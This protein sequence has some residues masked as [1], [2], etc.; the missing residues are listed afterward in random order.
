MCV[1][2]SVRWSLWRGALVLLS[3]LA[4][5]GCGGDDGS[6]DS[7]GDTITDG[8]E[9]AN[10]PNVDGD[11]YPNHLDLDSDGDGIPDAVEAGDAVLETPPV[12]TDGDADADVVDLDSDGDT[13]ADTGELAGD[14]TVADSDGDGTPDFRDLDSDGDGIPDAVEAVDVD[15]ATAAMDTNGDGTPD[16]RDGDSD[17]D[18]IPDAIEAG[19]NPAAPRYTDSDALPDYRDL[20]SDNDGLADSDEDRNCDGIVDAGESSPTSTDTDG[21]GT[22]DL[23]EVVAG[24]DPNNPGSNIPPGDFYFVLPY[25]GPGQSGPLDFSTTIKQADIFF[26][27][28]TTG[29]FGE[30]IAAIQN[31]IQNTI[32]P[33]VAAVIP[34]A[35]FGVGRF[36]DFPLAPFGL[37]GDR[38][39]AL[40]QPVTTT[41]AA[42]VAGLAALAP[43]SGGLDTPESGFEALYQWATGVGFPAFNYP[44]FSPPG[45]GGVGFRPDSLPIIIQI[46]D[47]ASHRASDYPFAA[48]SQ[49]DAVAA[50][51]ALGAR[52]IGVD[53]LENQGTQFDPRVQLEALAVATAATIPPS[54]GN[55]CMT[56]VNGAARPA[57]DLGGGNFTCPVVFDV[58]PNG[59]GLGALIVDAIAQ[60]ATL[61]TLDIST[62]KVG[63]LQGLRNEPLPSGTTTADFITTITPVAPPP[64]NATIVG[65]VFVNVTPGSTVT[66]L[67]DAF[68]DFVPAT[69]DDQLFA[70]D[71]HVLGDAVTLLDVRRVFVIV[72]RTLVPIN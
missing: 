5:A 31:T 10:R 21:D 44:A 45:I 57:L 24:S 8:D 13:I 66:F 35:A 63:Q 27:V 55:Q 25:L 37:A 11:S 3:V 61:G 14:F 2:H 41:T 64:P 68:N 47:A 26:S 53:S 33:G 22:P 58:L 36:E 69:A 60:L 52:V 19:A 12:D 51:T 40:L 67:V 38:A 72:P 30:E 28:D 34:N 56:G 48:H 59:N 6:I 7:D 49:A 4:I 71:I 46:T 16:F 9:R 54:A 42:V 17:G 65:E 39:F 20:D 62:A 15:P 1:E 23:V 50:L 32:I 18:C 43:A 70:I 29:S